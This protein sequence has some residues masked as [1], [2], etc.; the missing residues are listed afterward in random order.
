M[1][2]PSVML[3]RLRRILLVADDPRVVASMRC[4]HCHH[5]AEADLSSGVVRCRECDR[6]WTVADWCAQATAREMRRE[7]MYR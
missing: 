5:W 2:E 4:P 6:E 1:T 3:D 7:P